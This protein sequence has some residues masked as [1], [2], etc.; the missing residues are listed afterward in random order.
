MKPKKIIIVGGGI[1][2]LSTALH[3][4]RRGVAVTVL[5]RDRIGEGASSGNAGILA[6]A[7]PPL[8]R[9][10]LIGS[11]VRMVLDPASP[12]FIRL[13]PDPTLFSFLVRF[14]MACTKERFLASMD[15]L[16]TI[17]MEAGVCFREL[18]ATEQL[19]CEY[20]PQGW[21]EVFRD[22]N[23]YEEALPLA[24]LLRT[25]GYKVAE[26]TGRAFHAD[27]PSFRK[28]IHGA[29]HYEDSAYC[30]PDKFIHGLA[31]AVRKHGGTILESC[32]ATRI[33][34]NQ[35]S[36]QHVVAGGGETLEAD[37][38]VLAAGAWSTGLARTCGLRIPL[39]GGKGY[40]LV[41]D[42][43]ESRPT[44]T[45]VLAE[46]FV[47]VTPLEGGLRLAGTVELAGLNTT[48]NEDRCHQLLKGAAEYIRGIEKAR[49]RSTWC[50]LRPLTAGGLP[51]IGWADRVD[52]VFVA[53]GHAMMG[54]LLG[55]LTG[56]LASEAILDGA[57]SI[58]LTP[59]NL[60]GHLNPR[61]ATS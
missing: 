39:Q 29:L 20:S 47:A 31:D 6:L 33:I 51:A 49:I 1:V 61:A 26:R 7:H 60:D 21:L 50:G 27:E 25:R 59:F 8:P 35:G 17:G 58:D 30:H 34:V 41:L 19:T 15:V 14:A 13:R 54:F 12:V 32:E 5:E 48:M 22:P 56:R 11:A 43:T 38:M 23:H 10:G 24:D 44:T 16:C 37:H 57:S 3:L 4:A 52:R 40:H 36:F 46:R 28:Q 9:P 42:D 18:V 45:S 53:T 55:P 2:G